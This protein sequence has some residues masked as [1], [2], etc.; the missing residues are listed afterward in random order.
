MQIK[1]KSGVAVIATGAGFKFARF[2]DCGSRIEFET[3][4]ADGHGYYEYLCED[5]DS[6][7]DFYYMNNDGTLHY[8][9]H[10][11][12]V[13]DKHDDL[14]MLP[15]LG[16][17]NGIPDTDTLYDNAEKLLNHASQ[18]A[19]KGAVDFEDLQIWRQMLTKY[20]CLHADYM[21][22][23][24]LFEAQKR[25]ADRTVN[26]WLTTISAVRSALNSELNDQGITL[27]IQDN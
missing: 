7:N 6:G 14:P 26:S 15:N 20:P 19:F 21:A 2:E 25:V 9:V 17:D 23:G 16:P 3:Y 22:T 12:Q 27:V 10:V 24:S 8:C 18:L 1:Q 4:D 11:L 13:G 5:Y